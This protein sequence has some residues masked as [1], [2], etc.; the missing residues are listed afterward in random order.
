MIEPREEDIGRA[1]A[2]WRRQCDIFPSGWPDSGPPAVQRVQPSYPRLEA[3]LAGW[4]AGGTNLV[5]TA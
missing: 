4:K 5:I 2:R 3:I 1:A